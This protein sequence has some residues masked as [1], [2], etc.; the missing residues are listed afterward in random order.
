MR[1]DLKKKIL[2]VAIIPI[3]LLG[4]VIIF[5]TMT[6]VKNSLVNEVKDSLKGTASATLAA[7]DQNTGSYLKAEN[8]DVWKGGYNIS[9]SES[10]LDN[11]K[12]KT[13][14][15]VTFFY[16]SERI[17]T[18]AKDSKGERIL[19]SPAGDVIVEKVLKGGEEYFSS[20]VSLDGVMNYGYFIPVYQKGENV[21]PI[22]MVFV[23]TNKEAKDKTINSILFVVVSAVIIV[24][25]VCVVIAVVI[26]MSITNSLK[27]GIG[28]LQKV[29]DGELSTNIDNRLLKRKDEIGDLAKAIDVLQ[30]ALQNIISQISESTEKLT[31][32]AS[33]LGATAKETNI[34][35]KQV[36]TAVS[37]I[38]D[39]ISDQAKSTKSTSENIMVMG[40]QIGVTSREVDILSHNA[41][42]MRKS[43]EQATD[44]IRH[45]REINE[46]VENSIAII[47]RQTNLTNESAQKIRE[48]TA[49]ITAIAS[50]TNLL[51]LNASIE[52]ARAGDS[53]RGFAVVASQIQKLAE[54][55]N[56]SSRTIEEITGA[57]IKNSD[58]AVDIM[59]RV[60]EIIDSQSQNMMETE[61]I[62]S[63]VMDGIGTSLEKIEQIESTTIQLENSRNRIIETIGEL[64]DIAGQNVAS[65]QE[66]CAQTI[67]I[68][69]TFEEIERNAVNLKKIADNLSDT[70][71]YFRL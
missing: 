12:E 44:T 22:G 40:E 52:A 42:T 46:E 11:I 53:G 23:G 70:M 20:S 54:Q 6:Q 43:S 68:S 50:E 8:G 29:A 51:S 49:I 2:S 31:L 41:D 60:H 9:K 55:S 25:L 65:T 48:A 3:V 26:S 5:I 66:T 4:F 13:G 64:T 15:D 45:L 28:T 1:L 38:T 27:K 19:G 17:M 62:V 61:R 34:T 33:K 32:A 35:M 16:G 71:K 7:Y 21:D 10:L 30:R 14:M 18:S 57:L 59:S 24:V 47:T 37:S 58:E 56:E 36:E 69:N 67:E 63:E 39:N